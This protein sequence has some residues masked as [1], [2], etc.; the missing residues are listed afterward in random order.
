MH[1]VDSLTFPLVL[2]YQGK[3][4]FCW[5]FICVISQKKVKDR[6]SLTSAGLNLYSCELLHLLFQSAAA[7]AASRPLGKSLEL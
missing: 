4:V 5:Y 6:Q 2:R 1:L 3:I 7:Q